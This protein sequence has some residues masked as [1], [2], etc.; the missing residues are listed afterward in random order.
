[1]NKKTE[2]HSMKKIAVPVKPDFT[3]D[4]HFGH[5]ASYG[6][7]QLESNVLISKTLIPSVGGCGCKSGIA[8]TL[9]AEGVQLMLAGGIGAGAVEVLR[10]HGIDVIRGCT[11]HADELIEKYLKGELQDDGVNCAHHHDHHH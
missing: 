11:G 7:Y 4:D 3:I 1:M 6:I 10:N 2:T 8:S 5:C 9:A